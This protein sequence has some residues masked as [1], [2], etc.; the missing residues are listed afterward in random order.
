MICRHAAAGVTS[1]IGL[2]MLVF[3]HI[4][5]SV[6]VLCGVAHFLLEHFPSIQYATDFLLNQQS[7]LRLAK[8]GE[9]VLSQW[10]PLA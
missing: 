7:I 1:L 8:G 9:I 4:C 2:L 5:Q 3:N 6:R 10:I